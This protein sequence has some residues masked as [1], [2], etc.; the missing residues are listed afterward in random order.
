MK[1]NGA[2]PSPGAAEWGKRAVFAGFCVFLN[3]KRVAK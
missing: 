2:R 3:E 1:W